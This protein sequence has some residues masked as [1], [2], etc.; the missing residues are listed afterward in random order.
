MH[1]GTPGTPSHGPDHPLLG[2][3][4]VGW[5]L[6]GG[7]L[8]E[9]HSGA[10]W[11]PALL[12][13]GAK[14]G[15]HGSPCQGGTGVPGMARSMT[16]GGTGRTCSVP[17]LAAVLPSPQPHVGAPTAHSAP[18]SHVGEA[19]TDGNSLG[20]AAG[21]IVMGRDI[22]FPPP[23]ALPA[24]WEHGGH[25]EGLGAQVEGRVGIPCHGRGAKEGSRGRLPS[26]QYAPL[27]AHPIWA[28]DVPC[29]QH[30]LV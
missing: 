30:W 9:G 21:N 20:Q 10:G 5:V 16:A 11:A 19:R 4:G 17:W 14:G 1:S 13:A 15:L 29:C 26:P 22:N 7:S 27:P 6:A 28:P 23:G 2:I 18:L 8:L 3:L 24:C 12:L 25:A